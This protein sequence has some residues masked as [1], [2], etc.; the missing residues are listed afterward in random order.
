MKVSDEIQH[1]EYIPFFHDGD[2]T[3]SDQMR[4]DEMV[5]DAASRWKY[6]YLE[7]NY[8]QLK[9]LSYKDF[10]HLVLNQLC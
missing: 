10:E 3:L 9:C 2:Y 4:R 6:N 5:R 8:K 7:F 1:Y